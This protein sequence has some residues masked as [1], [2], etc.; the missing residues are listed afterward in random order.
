MSAANID[1]LLTS[2]VERIGSS[3]FKPYIYIHTVHP[4]LTGLHP[5]NLNETYLLEMTIF[6]HWFKISNGEQDFDLE[7]K[8][9]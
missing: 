3:F 5:S 4:C 6:L 8:K 9:F 7:T 2:S 1:G